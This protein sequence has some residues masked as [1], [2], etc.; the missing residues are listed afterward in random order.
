MKRRK[1]SK[2]ARTSR[3]PKRQARK[4]VPQ[5]EAPEGKMDRDMP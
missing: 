5:E 2:G 4:D 3:M 1:K